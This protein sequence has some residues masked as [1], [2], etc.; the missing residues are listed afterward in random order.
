MSS[1][2]SCRLKSHFS[3]FRAASS[4]RGLVKYLTR[5]GVVLFLFMSLSFLHVSSSG[6]ARRHPLTPPPS[7]AYAVGAVVR[8]TPWVQAV[9]SESGREG[10]KP[11]VPPEA[12]LATY[13]VD[14][15]LAS[16]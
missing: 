5:V 13:A 7:T 11:Q 14:W 8:L 16:A 15:P 6:I 12:A 4:R 10:R 2:S 1:R 3:A 9:G